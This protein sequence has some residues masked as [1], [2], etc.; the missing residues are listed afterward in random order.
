ML[1]VHVDPSAT[2]DPPIDGALAA[3]APQLRACGV[4]VLPRFG[5][6][7]ELPDLARV[8]TASR[9]VVATGCL[10][11]D[12]QRAAAQHIAE[13]AGRANLAVDVVGYVRPQYQCVESHYARLVRAGAERRRFPRYAAA[14]FGQPPSSGSV[15][16]Y[17]RA[18]APW[19]D[20][21][22]AR[23]RAFPLESS[24]VPDGAVAHFLGVLGTRDLAAP[25][26]AYASAVPGAKEL[27][28]YRRVAGALAALTPADRRERLARLAELPTLLW[29]DEA[30]TGFSAAE[31]VAVMGDFEA[32]NAAFAR[33]YGIDAAGRLFVDPVADALDRP[34]AVNWRDIEGFERRTVREFVAA[35]V[36]VDVAFRRA[37]RRAGR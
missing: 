37:A 34:S 8:S 17:R 12:A 19:R 20:A 26:W 29:P 18:F 13:A 10:S 21:F 33:D 36:G 2:G 14:Y 3:L 24:C 30:F 32:A 23:V 25:D 16:D 5:A 1:V 35:A 27:A 15:L 31:A 22:G 11:G 4:D 9:F 7:R 28:V 6:G